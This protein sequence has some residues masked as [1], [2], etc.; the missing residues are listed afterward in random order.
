MN[1]PENFPTMEAAKSRRPTPKELAQM[2]EIFVL[3]PVAEY[4]WESLDGER[5]ASSILAGIVESFAID[6]DTACTDML[7]FLAELEVAGLITSNP[8]ADQND[9]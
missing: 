3:N 8:A 6:E 7:E 5:S 9:R 1:F 4:I 2:Q